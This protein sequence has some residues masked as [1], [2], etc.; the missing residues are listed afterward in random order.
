L[1]KKVVVC[2]ASTR[3]HEQVCARFYTDVNHGPLIAF[4]VYEK[5]K[6]VIE[7]YY[8]QD[9]TGVV[10]SM[11]TKFR[12]A[13]FPVTLAA[14]DVVRFLEGAP[15]QPRI[16]REEIV[17]DRYLNKKGLVGV[18]GVGDVYIAAKGS[19]EPGTYPITFTFFTDQFHGDMLSCSVDN[20]IEDYYFR[21]GDDSIAHFRDSSFS[22]YFSISNIRELD[23]SMYLVGKEYEDI[24]ERRDV[25]FQFLNR[26]AIKQTVK[27]GRLSYFYA[28]DIAV[29]KAYNN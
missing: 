29:K 13:K 7:N 6:R 1:K 10:Q 14:F 23:M 17:V 27:N 18:P 22:R 12:R 19:Y 3:L 28:K 25:D 24:P 16:G 11:R 15:V 5:G 2:D 21:Q 8:Y 4:G 20:V 9:D 26:I